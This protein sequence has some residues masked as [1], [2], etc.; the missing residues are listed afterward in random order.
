MCACLNDNSC[1]YHDMQ[2]DSFDEVKWS[3]PN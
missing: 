1:F 2:V 3:E